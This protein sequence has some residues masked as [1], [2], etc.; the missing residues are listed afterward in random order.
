VLPPEPARA[1]EPTFA[2][3]GSDRPWPAPDTDEQ[4]VL[5]DGPDVAPTHG[6]LNRDS[7]PLLHI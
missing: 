5:I 6:Q 7:R 2:A 4:L 3:K 1:V